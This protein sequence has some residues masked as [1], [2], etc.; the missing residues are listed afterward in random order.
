MSYT[1]QIRLTQRILAWLFLVAGAPAIAHAA[2]VLVVCPA[3]FRAALAPWSEYREGQGHKL[4]TVEPPQTAKELHTQIRRAAAE[5]QLQYI[6]LVGDVRHARSDTAFVPTDYVNARVNVRWGSEPTIASDQPYADLD[7]DGVPD[8]AVGRLPA[9]TPAELSAVVRKIISYEQQTDEG[10]WRRKVNIVAGV[11]GFGAMTDALVEAAGRSVIQQTVPSSYDVEPSF[12][13]ATNSTSPS[14]RF[15]SRV[16]D[17]LS[18]G[19]LAWIY[20]GHG[21]PTELDSIHTASGDRPILSTD[22][23]PQLRCGP[24]APLAVL[25]ACYTGAVDAPQQCLAERLVLHNRGPIAA[26][27]ATRVTMPYGN[28]V[29]GCE[30]LRACF[31]A[32]PA[33][34]GELFKLAETR[35]LADAPND[36]LRK[37]LD[38]LAAGLSPPPVDLA[39]ERREHVLMYQLLGDPLLRLQYPHDLQLTAAPEEETGDSLSIDC[40]SDITGECTIELVPDR[41]SSG[42][43]RPAAATTKS[44]ASGP[45]RVVLS[46]PPNTAGQYT[47]R[48]F[49]AGRAEFAMGATPIAIPSK[50]AQQI[51]RAMRAAIIK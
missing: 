5:N 10:I 2:D 34:L 1:F 36:P 14:D 28:A 38:A 46:L 39:A 25:I 35:T 23:M 6:V 29:L 9:H 16:C 8:V 45:F 24:N 50:P 31:G 51:S 11:G 37:S 26:I 47:L 13:G 17:Q 49:V 22:D 40:R 19:S 32:H 27:A 4:L 30:L 33:T 12:A 3:E 44:V 15:T 41:E 20:L 42:N 21:L 18:A 43:S 7:G 48:G